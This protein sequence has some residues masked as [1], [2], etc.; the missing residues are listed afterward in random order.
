MKLFSVL[1]SLF[2]ALILSSIC[3]ADSMNTT[4][5]EYY[6]DM[7]GGDYMNTTTGEYYMDLD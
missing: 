1:T 6:M 3:L 5:G 2:L 4:T 7:G